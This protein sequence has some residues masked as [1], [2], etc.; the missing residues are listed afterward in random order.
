MQTH[1]FPG[2]LR[3]SDFPLC[4]RLRAALGLAASTDQETR[5]DDQGRER[6]DCHAEGG[7]VSAG[8]CD[9]IAVRIR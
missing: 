5:A 2:A 1:L 4:P 6:G 8:I 3:E 9:P 7:R